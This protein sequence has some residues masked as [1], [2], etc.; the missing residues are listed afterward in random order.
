MDGRESAAQFSERYPLLIT[1]TCCHTLFYDEFGRE[2][3]YFWL[4]F[5]NF[6]IT[7]PCLRKICRKRDPCLENFGPENPTIWVA[8]TC[9]LNMLCNPHPPG[10]REVGCLNCFSGETR[11]L[12]PL[13]GFAA[14]QFYSLFPPR[15]AETPSL[16]ATLT[17]IV[18]NYPPTWWPG[19]K[20]TAPLLLE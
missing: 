3:T 19:L 9:T 17:P 8:H 20:M 6:F 16:E 11:P 12:W 4:F 14:S 15:E 1:V 13:K 2:I 18:R 7:H 5:A 10:I